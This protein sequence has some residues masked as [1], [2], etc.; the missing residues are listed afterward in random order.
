M[1]FD[2]LYFIF[3]IPGFLLAGWASLMVKTS[4]AKYSRIGSR[5][6][7]TGAQAARYILDHN[8][9]PDVDIERTGGKLTDH[10]D[11]R[12]R[13]LRLSPD[14][15]S[16]SSIAAIGIAAHESGHALQHKAGY[17]PLQLRSLLV[18]A[19]SFGSN[20][21]W[22]FITLGVM[23]ASGGAAFGLNLAKFGLL[24]FGA[25]V[26]FSVVTLPVEFNAS[27]R[28]KAVLTQ[29]GLVTADEMQGVST[30]LNAAAMTYVAAAITAILQLLY[31]VF[32]LGL[33]G[34][35]DD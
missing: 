33:L 3:L 21:A 17:A 7:M 29:Y 9:L 16:M 26:L 28:A 32:R 23:M 2:P 30:I 14:V 10:Y 11:P 20:A 25:A 35:R 6:G 19:A 18:P 27:S 12:T 31:W 22:I 15:Y 34:G 13:I 1:F 24:L 8:G 4:Y 5:T